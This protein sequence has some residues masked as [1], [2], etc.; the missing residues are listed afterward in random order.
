MIKKSYIFE[1]G[2][3]DEDL[4]VSLDSE[5]TLLLCFGATN[6]SY[7]AD[8]LSDITD[9]F[10]NSKILGCSTSG[11]IKDDLLYEKSLVVEVIQFEKTK[12]KFY[13]EELTSDIDSFQIG[14]N[15]GNFFKNE[16]NLKSIFILSDGLHTNGSK[17]TKG[18][19]KVLSNEVVITGG[20]AGDD[21]N[22]TQ[23]WVLVNGKPLPK[24]ITAIGFYGDDFRIAYG[25]EGGWQKFGIDRMVTQAKDN[26]LYKLDDK[27]ALEVYKT[28]L[29]EHSKDLP[30]SGLLYPLMIKEEGYVEAKVRTILAVDE[31]TQ[32]IT[33][34]GDIPN[35]SEVMFMKATFEQLINGALN[36]GQQLHDFSYQNE[37]GVC[38]AVSCVGRKLVLGQKIE[39][40]LET[41]RDLLPQNVDL[42]GY[43]SYGEISPLSNGECDLHNQTMTV[44]LIWEV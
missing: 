1:D 31:E 14:E 15:L 7:I 23:T 26:V 38:I 11:E 27:P 28:Y 34:A 12:L 9:K 10:K 33:F 3:W 39:D 16:N 18:L 6:S 30:A 40:E 35:G 21:A 44:S 2:N 22:F 29:G 43:Y 42:L 37:N 32:S 20:L 5:N 24:Y 13:F 25:S 36:A 19:N 4:D 8:G 41:I 17:L